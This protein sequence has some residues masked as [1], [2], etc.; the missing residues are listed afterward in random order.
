MLTTLIAAALA[1]AASATP[2][3]DYA[4]AANW[5]CRPGRKDA[6]AVDQD[7]TVI[8]A[9]GTRK[10]ERFKPAAA[11]KFDCFYVYP[12]LSHDPGQNSDMTPKPEE[13]LVVAA[14]AAR[15][16]S[17]CRVFAP[18][19]RQ[20]TLTALRAAI[21][22]GAADHRPRNGLCRREGGVGELSRARQQGARRR[23]D[24]AQPGLGH[25]QAAD[26]QRD[27]GQAGRQADDR[28]LSGRHQR[29]RRRPEIHA[30]LH[31]R[32]PE[33]LRGRLGQL[34]RRQPAAGQFALRPGSTASRRCAS[35]PPT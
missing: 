12:T 13:N 18:M 25:P 24:R 32:E 10:V 30:R 11:P 9:D 33:R 1:Q 7:V 20:V 8:A 27:R 16:A 14:Q 5:L 22:S 21:T 19:Y 28:R 4:D 31:Q 34:P 17:Q 29:G 23:P 3:P 35:T 15:F 2:A 26:R 6:C